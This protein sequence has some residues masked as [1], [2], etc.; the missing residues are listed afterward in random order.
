[1]I[2]SA[3]DVYFYELIQVSCIGAWG[4]QKHPILLLS[5]L[6]ILSRIP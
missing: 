5:Q 1:M 4:W 2:L 6:N 3:Q